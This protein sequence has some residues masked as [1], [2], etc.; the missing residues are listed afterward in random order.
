MITEE[1]FADD[2][3]V[4][5]V[6]VTFDRGAAV[7]SLT[8]A[9]IRASALKMNSDPGDVQDAATSITGNTVTCTWAPGALSAGSWRVQVKVTKSGQTQT[10]RQETITVK[11]SNPPAS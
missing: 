7:S 3:L 8:G 10:V 1:I 4:L 9:T 6:P 11:P 5:E 2:G